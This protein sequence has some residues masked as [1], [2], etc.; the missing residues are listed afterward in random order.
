MAEPQAIDIEVALAAGNIDINFIGAEGAITYLTL[1]GAGETALKIP[2]SLDEAAA[3]YGGVLEQ[4]RW[5]V[6]PIDAKPKIKAT[7]HL[8]IT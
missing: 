6:S 7:I 1:Q 3:L 4:Q 2:V 8:E 5:R